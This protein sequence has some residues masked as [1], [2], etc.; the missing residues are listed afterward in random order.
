MPGPRVNRSQMRLGDDEDVR[1]G[2]SSEYYWKYD[3]AANQY[4][5]H[6]DD[7]GTGNDAVL[8][9]V[10]NLSDV[11]DITRL[12]VSELLDVNGNVMAKS[13]AASGQTTLSSGTAVVDTGIS[14]TDATFS[15]ALGIDD[16]NADAKITG[17]LFWD[18]S[19]GTYKIEIVEDGTSVGNPTVNYDVVRVR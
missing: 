2:A 5:L 3:S 7:D 10:D 6:T 11:I 16:P 14:A 17:R 15:L 4:E 19:A 13:V 9:K 12:G 1:Y 18:D 8:L